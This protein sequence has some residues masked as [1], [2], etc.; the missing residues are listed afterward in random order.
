MEKGQ[1]RW[2]ET[3][4]HLRCRNLSVNLEKAKEGAELGG[5]GGRQRVSYSMTEGSSLEQPKPR[6]LSPRPK[7]AVGRTSLW[8]PSTG[9]EGSARGTRRPGNYK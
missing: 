1:P 2:R 9:T 5:G 7:A 8:E 6:G 4:E 3:G